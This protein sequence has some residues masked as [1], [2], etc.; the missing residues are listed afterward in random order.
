[1][2]LS[3]SVRDLEAAGQHVARE[4]GTKAHGCKTNHGYVREISWASLQHQPECNQNG[5]LPL[6]TH[7]LSHLLISL[8]C[9]ISHTFGLSSFL[10]NLL[11][12]TT[13]LHIHLCSISFHLQ[14]WYS[15]PLPPFL[16][17]FASLWLKQIAEVE[18]ESWIELVSVVNKLDM[19]VCAFIFKSLF[20]GLNKDN[21]RF[22]CALR[23]HRIYKIH[24]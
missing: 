22:Q 19:P 11:L 21:H 16:P 8:S 6:S 17:L 5:S 13:H 24:D 9:W 20:P 10:P 4:F 18:R 7:M 12:S 2:G 1:M 3:G 15:W 14:P 23:P